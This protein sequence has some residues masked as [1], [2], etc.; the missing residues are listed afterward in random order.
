MPQTGNAYQEAFNSTLKEP[1]ITPAEFQ[2]TNLNPPANY[3]VFGGCQCS[4]TW[5]VDGTKA[6][7]LQVMGR[8]TF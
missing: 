4:D 6:R 7:R 8:F 2:V 5:P 1:I 3:G